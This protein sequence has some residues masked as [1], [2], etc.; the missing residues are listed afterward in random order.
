MLRHSTSGSH[1][2]PRKPLVEA[3]VVRPTERPVHTDGD[4]EMRFAMIFCAPARIARGRGDD[5]VPHHRE[6]QLRACYRM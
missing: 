2:E 4:K 1:V 5:D 6:A 3:R